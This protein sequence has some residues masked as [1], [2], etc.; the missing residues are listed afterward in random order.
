ML[1]ALTAPCF[2]AEWEASQYLNTERV[3]QSLDAHAVQMPVGQIPA[4]GLENL[5][6]SVVLQFVLDDQMS[7]RTK[8][9]GFLNRLLYRKQVTV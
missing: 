1:C 9:I 2:N 5:R 4:A 6:V 8:S 7:F 3:C